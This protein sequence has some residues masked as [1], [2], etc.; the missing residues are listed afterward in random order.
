MSL[1]FGLMVWSSSANNPGLDYLFRTTVSA[2]T[3]A[4]TRM[5]TSTILHAL[6]N[7]CSGVE[8]A[9]RLAAF[10]TIAEQI[11]KVT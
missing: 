9:S 7:F 1:A 3:I 8:F 6:L 4:S 11:L 10:V 5:I 2:C